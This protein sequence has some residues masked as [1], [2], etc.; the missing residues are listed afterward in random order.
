MQKRF[1]HTVALLGALPL[2]SVTAELPHLLAFLSKLLKLPPDQVAA[3]LKTNFPAL[4]QAITNLPGVTG[5][6][7]N[8]PGV[9]GLTRF[10]G[11]PVKTVPQL[12]SYYRSDLVPALAAQQGNFDSLDGTSSVNWIAPL[13]LI[14]GLVVIVFAA[15]MIWRNRS[16]VARREAIATSVVVP[17]VGVVV[18][19]LVLALSLI[20][21]TSDG[22]KLLDGLRPA[23]NTP[24]V[25]GDRAGIKMVS[26]IV[27]MEDPI[28]TPSGGAAAEV[29]KLIAFV[30]SKTGL[31]PSAVL[32]ALKTNFPH[33]TALLGALPLTAVS[34]EL[35]GVVQLLGPGVVTA[36]P[37][38]A[39]TVINAPYVTGGWNHIPGAAGLTRF[40]GRP[41]RTVPQLRT[42][43][44]AD[45]IPVLETQRA[46]YVNLTK[47]SNIDF[48]G[49]LVL[50][51]GLIVIAFGL[52][53]VLLAWR[54]P[55]P[56]PRQA[57]VSPALRT[58]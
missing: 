20:P 40:D 39:Q 23:W 29:P 42:Y 8:V 27:D 55:G 43:L 34:S 36:V 33:T 52:L 13:L 17:V 16:G 14:V 32:A 18:V 41:V 56:E 9:A 46:N 4:N 57:R 58:G 37:R 38:L 47:T 24:R 10:N 48:I 35:T 30:S 21:R 19:A 54:R 25:I 44:S 3:A 7:D 51:V 12:R 22:Q 6:W 53:M 49:P 50:I 28:M 26:T 5:G 15:V 31:P 2:S 1:P 11:A 45:V